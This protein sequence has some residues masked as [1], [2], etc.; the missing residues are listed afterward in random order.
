MEYRNRYPVILIHGMLGWGESDGMYRHAPYWGMV[1]GNQAK[2]LREDGVEAYAVKVGP[3]DSAWDRACELYALLRGTAVDYGKAHAEKYRHKRIG[4]TY[5]EPLVEHWG[6]DPGDGGIRKVHLIGHSFGGVTMRLLAELL[7]NGSPEER[8]VTPAE[9][10]SPLFE[11]GHGD[12]IC[13]LTSVSAPHDGTTFVHLFPNFMKILTAGVMT[14]FSVLGNTKANRF[15][16]TSLDQFELTQVPGQSNPK[17]ILDP[18]QIG[19]IRKI[20]RTGDH[21]FHDLRIDAAGEINKTISCSPEIYYF[22]LTGN[23]TKADPK[24]PENQIREPMMIFA[25]APFAKK[26]GCVAEQKIGDT[27]VTSAWR[28]NDGLVPVESGRYPHREPH[29]DYRE[30]MQLQ[31]GIWHVLPDYIGDH[32]TVIGGS[33]AYI[34]PGRGEPYRA[35]YRKH[36]DRLIGLE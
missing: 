5:A 28:A 34:G 17:Q 16:D 30:G 4:R 25:F 18:G 10:L 31:K 23:G 11:G 15:F 26:M 8:A 13:S 9:E 27:E 21:V 35:F 33:L 20:L 2:Q 32:G 1:T 24:H 12:W 3:A 6:E 14:A 29:V 19:K 7:T 36:I 22:S